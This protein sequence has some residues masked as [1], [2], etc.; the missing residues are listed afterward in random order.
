M[1]DGRNISVYGL[2]LA[3]LILIVAWEVVEHN[4]VEESARTALL[5]RARDIS[6]TVGVVIR[7]RGRGQ[8]VSQS[9]LEAALKGLAES[10]ELKSVALLNAQWDVVASAGDPVDL[11][12][13]NLPNSGENWERENL[14]VV[15]LVD[16]GTSAQPDGATR[17]TIIMPPPTPRSATD[18]VQSVSK[19]SPPPSRDRMRPRFPWPPDVTVEMASKEFMI[20]GKLPENWPSGA[21]EYVERQ[22]QPRSRRRSGRGGRRFGRPPWMNKE[23]YDALL[24][25]QG[26]HGFVLVIS[27]DAYRLEI[28]RDRWLRLGI[29]GIALIAVIGLALARRNMERS[30]ELQLRLVRASEM[31]TRLKEMNLAAAGL[32][33]ETRNPL[34]IVRGLAQM[35]SRQPEATAD[36]KNSSRNITEEVDRVTS[37]LNEFIEYSRPQQPKPNPTCLNTVVGDVDRTLESD[38]EDKAIEFEIKG[39]ELVVDADESLLR[40]VVFNLMLN[41]IQAA[42]QGG[43]IEVVVEKVN[44]DEAAFEIRDNGLGV[45]AEHRDDI[46]RPY[47]TTNAEGSGLGLAVVQQIVLAHNWDIEYISSDDS[48]ARF[49]ISGIKIS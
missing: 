37:R 26:L 28:S 39:P 48:G 6:N 9:R 33:H 3:A 5:G 15:N 40:Q 41:A 35:I 17:P 19:P 31:N 1:R 14:T 36:I 13:E 29:M 18:T 16:L 12:P 11:D 4:R 10:E 47:F 43:K 25:K 30:A 45:A 22:R 23:R 27:T 2:L 38:K 44:S 8:F 34:N 21:T 20:R 32:A 46:F 42:D 24:K 7:S 49:R